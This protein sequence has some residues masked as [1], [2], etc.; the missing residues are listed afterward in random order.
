MDISLS[1]LPNQTKNVL[2]NWIAR[3]K[4]IYLDV[5]NSIA[6]YPTLL[7]GVFLLLSVV[8]MRIEF[9]QFVI[10]FKKTIDQFLVHDEENA[11]LIL[12]TIVG[13]LISLMV[14]SFSM[15]MVVLN[16]T[17]STLS[18]RVLPGLISNKFH[19]FVLGFYSGSIVFS[20]VLI[21]NIN[22][23]EVEY[24]VPSL[25]ILIS[26]SLAVTCLALFVYFIHSISQKI[27]VENILEE[28]Y[29]NT[30]KELERMPPED[31]Q[32]GEPDTEGWFTCAATNS[33]YLKRI[34]FNGLRRFCEKE[35]VIIK[36]KQ[37]LG[38]YV[39]KNHPLILVDR[40]LT[41]EMRLNLM[42][43][44][45][46]YPEERVSD[47]YSFGF[48][49]ISEI[50]VKA[51]S[52]GINDPGT[53]IKAIN[54]LA[55]LFILRFTMEE[56][57]VLLGEGQ[58]VYVYLESLSVRKLLFQTLIPIQ[59]YGKA[60]VFVIDTLLGSIES[61]LFG[62]GEDEEHKALLYEMTIGIKVCLACIQS[63]IDKELLNERIVAINQFFGEK[64]QI[65]HI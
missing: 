48:K 47:H 49:L 30:K 46:M 1:K 33:G 22:S 57:K 51:L 35:H 45:V 50:A 60:D 64:E 65:A 7:S 4:R 21:I 17:T 62:V 40:P 11:R 3:S 8:I 56:E 24:S 20:L 61:M 59:N 58:K 39:I 27:Q 26:L 31:Q 37:S 38:S 29:L 41:D 34:D 2:K 54:L 42:G 12:G 43:L 5:I 44:F 9:N 16:N 18:P 10:E 13:S 19:Q 25:G 55:D 6:F 53:A 23:P 14:F 36:V 28:I 52:P 63:A 15:V 32:F